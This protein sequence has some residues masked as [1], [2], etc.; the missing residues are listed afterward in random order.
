VA[1]PSGPPDGIHSFSVLDAAAATSVTESA[2]GQQ[3]DYDDD[4]EDREHGHLPGLGW[5]GSRI[6]QWL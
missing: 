3:Q 5:V 1:I 4:E 2:A 6:V